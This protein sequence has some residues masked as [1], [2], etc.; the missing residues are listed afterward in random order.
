MVQLRRGA[1]AKRKVTSMETQLIDVDRAEW[2]V[3]FDAARAARTLPP[4]LPGE[5]RR[6]SGSAKLQTGVAVQKARFE[7]SMGEYVGHRL[8]RRRFLAVSLFQANWNPEL[9]RWLCHLASRVGAVIASKW[10]GK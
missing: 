6:K 8:V 3:P 1:D 10:L 2:A 4:V 5:S 9:L 7:I